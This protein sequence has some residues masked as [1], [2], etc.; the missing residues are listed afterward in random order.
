M[1]KNPGEN[2][3]TVEVDSVT[4]EYVI[5]VPEWIISEYGWYEGTEVNME[6]DGD[7]IVITDL[8]N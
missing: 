4:G 2:F 5:K 3:T 6:V 8:N 7:A 1:Q